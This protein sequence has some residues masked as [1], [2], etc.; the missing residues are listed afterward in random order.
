MRKSRFGGT[1]INPDK[2][3]KSQIKFFL[4]LIPV[5][6]FM[7]L[8]I[9]FIFNHAFKPFNELFAFPPRFFVQRPTLINFT[10][11]FATRQLGAMPM[12]RY[13]FNSITVAGVIVVL[14]IVIS[15]MAAYALSKKDFKLKKLMFEINTV[16]L[17]FVPVA[18]AIPRYLVVSGLGLI[19]SFWV[20][21]IPLIA[22]P[23]GLFL[24]KQF[25]DQVPDSLIEAAKIDG[26]SDY[27]IYYKIVL[28]LVKP[29]VATVAILSFQS[30][31]N[32]IETSAIYITNESLRTFAFFM[33]S[34]GGM[35]GELGG[36]VA[37]AGISAAASLLM[38]VPNL[39]IFIFMQSKV[40]DTMAHSGIK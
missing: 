39:L 33:N 32:N 8:P 34:L 21:I 30:A 20:H 28:P 26:A 5:A 13:F 25:M 22:M 10:T 7:A 29:A 40:M 36:S 35:G 38:F 19:D 3:D 9:I 2:F 12:S 31:W 6:I 16:A 1:K 14:N 27:Y 15:T 11:L 24:L 37:A 18:V 4:I 23:V 17:M